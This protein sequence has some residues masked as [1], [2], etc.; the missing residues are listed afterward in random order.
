MNLGE[1]FKPVRDL[2][3]NIRAAEGAMA[4]LHPLQAQ[5]K[6]ILQ[7]ALIMRRIGTLNP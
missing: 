1:L 2:V 4:L 7:Q 6:L 5:R 3:R